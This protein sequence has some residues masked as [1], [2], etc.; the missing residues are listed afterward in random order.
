LCGQ[1]TLHPNATEK[2]GPKV[3]VFFSIEENVYL[4]C[5]SKLLLLF[6]LCQ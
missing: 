1:H 2:I 3:K 4:L 6:E 5:D